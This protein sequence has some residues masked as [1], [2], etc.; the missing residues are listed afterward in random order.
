MSRLRATL[1]GALSLE[2][3]AIRVGHRAFTGRQL[4]VLTVVMVLR[5]TRNVPVDELAV[6]LWPDAPPEHWRAALR[7]LVSRLR[8]I[9]VEL[10]YPDEALVAARGTYRV[11]LGDVEVD[12]EAV[13]HNLARARALLDDGRTEGARRLVSAARQVASRP[14]LAGIDAPILD[15]VRRSL[16][17][18]RLDALDLLAECRV[19]AGEHA[20]AATAAREAVR[21]DAFREASWRHLMMAQAGAGNVAM[22]LRGHEQMR[23]LFADQLGVDPSPQTQALHADL[24]R[25]T[26]DARQ[27]DAGA[28]ASTDSDDERVPYRGLLAFR[29]EDADLFFGRD[30]HV[31]ELIDRL[32]P[33]R[34]VA[35]TGPSGSGKSSVVR[36]GLLPALAA[37]ALPESDTWTTILVTP[38]DDPLKAPGRRP[39]R[40]RERRGRPGRPA[41]GRRRCPG[42]PGAFGAAV[43]SIGPHGPVAGRG[44]PGRGVVHHL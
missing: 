20:D 7:G 5:R 15:G 23:R 25:T 40:C 30:V 17:E 38:G 36:A 16:H 42:Q 8:R 9:L 10:G 32:A 18:Q 4:P 13:S 2:L 12:V 35:V 39:G 19:R 43:T 14:V 31:Q 41:V 3:G 22:A 11:E 34:A 28:T 44:G 26:A 29:P 33:A 27:V 24:L 1:A 6:Q 37:G 21:L